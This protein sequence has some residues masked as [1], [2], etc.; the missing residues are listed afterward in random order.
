M[1]DAG[2]TVPAR[3][4]VGSVGE[5]LFARHIEDAH[6]RLD[7]LVARMSRSCLTPSGHSWCLRLATRRVCVPSLGCDAQ[8]LHGEGRVV[9]VE[10]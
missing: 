1:H 3:D 5:G 6:A 8:R 7:A 10:L 2:G 4:E 9:R